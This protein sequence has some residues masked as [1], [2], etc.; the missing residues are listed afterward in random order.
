MDSVQ[1]QLMYTLM[2]QA[3]NFEFGQINL[4]LR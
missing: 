4:L 3:A 1:N 2:A